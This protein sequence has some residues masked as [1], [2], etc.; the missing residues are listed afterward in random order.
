MREWLPKTSTLWGL[1]LF[2]LVLT[3][4][5]GIVIAVFDLHIIDEISN[6][7]RVLEVVSSFGPEQRQA[8]FW[9]TLILDMPYPLAYGGFYI[10]LA[11]RFFG[12]W[13]PL[14]ALPALITIPADLIEN[15]AQLF[16]LAGQEHFAWIK[17]YV[18]P[19]KLAGFIPASIL[20][21][22]ALGL[23]VKRRFQA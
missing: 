23:A 7:D 16:I 6:P 4:G 13:G 22:I 11:L 15:T 17:Q 9:M 18:T 14:L 5:F 10:G 3:I 19:V 8:H 1:G 2:Y 12:R 20:A 21:I